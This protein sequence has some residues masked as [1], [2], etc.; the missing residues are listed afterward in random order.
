MYRN[1]KTISNIIF[2]FFIL[3]FVFSCSSTEKIMLERKQKDDPLYYPIWWTD[4]TANTENIL[5]IYTSAVGES[6][7]SSYLNAYS[8]LLNELSQIYSQIQD[9]E[10]EYLTELITEHKIESLGYKIVNILV[11]EN[12]E[13]NFECFIKG[14]L[15]LKARLTQQEIQQY[16][17]DRESIINLINQAKS[18]YR[19]YYDTEALEL[20]I[21]ALSISQ[22]YPYI[23]YS[24]SYEV[25]SQRI[26]RI[27]NNIYFVFL[28]KN[29]EDV[30]FTL[31]VKRRVGIIHPIVKKSSIRIT[32]EFDGNNENFSYIC[33]NNGVFHY[34]S[35]LR[36]INSIG[37]FKI[38]INMPE[39]AD[40]LREDETLSKFSEKLSDLIDKNSVTF[41]Y[42]K[43]NQMSTEGVFSYFSL[44]D[45]NKPLNSFEFLPVSDFISNLQK[46]NIR[47]SHYSFNIEDNLF[48]D[49]EKLYTS[50]LI[51]ERY[52]LY[53]QGSVYET[54]VINRTNEFTVFITLSCKVYDLNEKKCIYTSYNIGGV[55]VDNN[56]EIAIEKGYKNALFVLENIIK[57]V[58]V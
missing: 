34:Q 13:V 19:S 44:N 1:I 20:Y 6:F 56:I 16:Q 15:D 24:L 37:E 49:E 57:G 53:V 11:I 31:Q 58:V 41:E 46:N 47:I 28:Q 21:K 36:N 14:S 3:F 10:N 50:L 38:S 33:D 18:L 7:T 26:E 5:Y 29:S 55:G 39:S 23:D 32:A 51:S 30:S 52:L 54:S 8:H 43:I 27:I 9:K 35:T 22:S 48:N 2:L 40:L 42:Q 4:R 12:A 25:L 17:Q 45:L